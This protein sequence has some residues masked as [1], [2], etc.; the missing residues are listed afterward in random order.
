MN[1]QEEAEEYKCHMICQKTTAMLHA[2]EQ[3]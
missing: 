1:Q 2:N 3:Q